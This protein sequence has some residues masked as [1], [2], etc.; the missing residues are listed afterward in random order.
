[1]R[2]DIKRYSAEINWDYAVIERLNQRRNSRPRV[3]P[4]CDGR[5]LEAVRLLG[6]KRV[7]LWN[8]DVPLADIVAA[9]SSILPFTR[10]HKIGKRRSSPTLMNQKIVGC[11]EP[12]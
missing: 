6:W 8:A 4:N 11:G 7:T 2:T 1:L 5:R 10:P 12:L 9:S 3:R